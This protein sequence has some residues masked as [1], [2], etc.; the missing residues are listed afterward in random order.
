MKEVR[1]IQLVLLKK[2]LEVCKRNNLRIWA[3]SGTLIGTV[4]EHGYI[5]WDDDIDMGMLRPD[6]DKLVEISQQEFTGRFFFQTAYSDK[7]YP[8]GH[9]QLRMRNTTAILPNDVDKPFHMGIFID[10]FVYDVVPSDAKE[11]ETLR[12]QVITQKE[13]LFS[14]CDK[15]RFWKV[16]SSPV[17]YFRHKRIRKEI[18]QIGFTKAYA[19]YENLFRA[20]PLK[21]DSYIGEIS[22]DFDNYANQQINV[23]DFSDTLYMPFED[24]Q[25]P[26][27]IGYDAILTSMYGDY[28]RPVQEPTCHGSY[29]LLDTTKDYSLHIES[30]RKSYSHEKFIKRWKHIFDKI[31]YYLSFGH[32]E[33]PKR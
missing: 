28:M 19:D 30:L 23:K 15:M 25:I 10:I 5:P 20:H 2:L 16:F 33:V 26:V 22:F 21:E 12:Q 14:Y 29:L 13:K 3:D 32:T 17:L 27:P 6:Y 1:S 7:E 8:R 9:A 4:R 18:S 31:L 11:L 24:T